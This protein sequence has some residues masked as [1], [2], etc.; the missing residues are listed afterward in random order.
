MLHYFYPIDKVIMMI[1]IGLTG[2]SDHRLLIEK[3]SQKLEDYSKHFPIVEMDTSFYAIP[4]ERNILSWIDK[5]PDRFQ[6][7]PKAYK[8]M[9]LH[10]DYKDDF[11]SLEEMFT[12]FKQ[13]FNPMI[14]RGKI[15]GFLFQFPPTFDCKK[16]H[17]DY[18][19]F[20]RQQM[21]HLTIAVEFRHPSWFE[22]DIAE[23]TLA[24]LEELN[25]INVVVD[26]PQTQTNSV[27]F[28]PEVT[29]GAKSIYRLHGR[30]FAGWSGEAT[31][32]WR[33]VRTL[34]DYSNKELEEIAETTRNLNKEAQSVLVIFNNNSGGHAAK[35]A[36][37]LQE[38]LELE[39]KGLG[40]QQTHLDLF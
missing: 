27:P 11:N 22:G 2:W 29:N 35:N 31:D 7:F 13:T 4:P 20:V 23:K 10:S 19:R 14:A 37:K 24:F 16:E 26:Q 34:W 3:Q 39:F 6:F 5:T 36:K 30:N 33:D 12:V 18:L 15:Y 38:L 25:F 1:L 21:Q 17:V 32:H 40:P 9:T 28:M 8:A